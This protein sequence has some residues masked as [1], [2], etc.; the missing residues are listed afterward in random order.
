MP[1]RRRHRG[2]H[3]ADEAL[4][5]EEQLPALRRAVGDLSWLLTRGYAPTASLKLVGDRFR[6]TQRQRTAVMR[7]ACSDDARSAR[8]RRCVPAGQIG[9]LALEIDGFNLLT[10]VEAAL[11]GAVLLIG[12]DGCCRDLTS[13]HG[14]YRKV[15]ESLPAL[16]LIGAC[17]AGLRAGP[18]RW[19]FDRPVSNSGRIAQIVE[20][21]GRQ[22]GWPWRAEP[23]TD[24]DPVLRASGEVVV[25]ADS[26]ILDDCRRWLNLAA[27]VVRDSV[28]DAWIV[29]LG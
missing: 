5:A 8:A 24:P 23:C 3:P 12:R 27:E 20:D 21:V 6:L 11:S 2:P 28:P 1:D 4:F 18:C 9:G 13:M 29:D 22:E 16:R 25:S 15:D 7:T 26:V 10:T 14:S 19:L 17:L